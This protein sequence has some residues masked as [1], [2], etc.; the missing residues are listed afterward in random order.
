MDINCTHACFYQS[1]G[2]CNLNELPA[3]TQNSFAAH[4][5]DCPYYAEPF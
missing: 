4:N 2:K 5:I 1:D 3:Y